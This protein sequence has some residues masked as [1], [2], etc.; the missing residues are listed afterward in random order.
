MIFGSSPNDSRKEEDLL[1]LLKYHCN[2]NILITVTIHTGDSR[3]KELYLDRHKAE[4][5]KKTPKK[6]YKYSFL[7]LSIFRQLLLPQAL[8]L[9][10]NFW[11]K[12]FSFLLKAQQN[13]TIKVTVVYSTLPSPNPYLY[14]LWRGQKIACFYLIPVFPFHSNKQIRARLMTRRDRQKSG[15][16]FVTR[17]L[18][19]GSY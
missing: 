14:P 6:P 3:F 4:S 12:L 15:I 13:L 8:S 10:T 7:I 2:I 5:G 11:N 19:S 16:N 17:T 18:M 9:S 1:E